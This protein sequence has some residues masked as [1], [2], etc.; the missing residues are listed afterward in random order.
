MNGHLSTPL[1]G[2]SQ[3]ADLNV[4]YLHLHLIKIDLLLRSAVRRWQLAGQDFA[5][6]FRGLFI[7]EEDVRSLLSRPIGGNWGTGVELPEE[8]ADTFR[9]LEEQIQHEIEQMQAQAAVRGE[10]LRLDDMK[11]LFR[12][13]QFEFDAFMLCVAPMLDTRYERIFGYLQD[14][15]TNHYAGI[16]LILD[17]LLTPG[18]DR[19]FY[20]D[21]FNPEAA[22]RKYDLI[23]RIDNGDEGQ[24]PLIRQRFF[25]PAEIITWLRGGYQAPERFA[26]AFRLQQGSRPGDAD[27]AD[28]PQDLPAMLQEKPLLVLY[29]QDELQQHLAARAIA[30]R[31][32]KP[33]LYLDLRHLPGGGE[34]DQQ[35][36]DLLAR[37]AMLTGA[38]PTVLGWERF[39]EGQ[40]DLD[41]FFQMLSTYPGVILLF[42]SQSW[43]VLR[44]ERE[45]IKAVVWLD[46]NHP[47]GTRRLQLWQHYLG[48]DISLPA[49]E[50]EA[51]SGQ[52]TLTA[53]QIS[54]AVFAAKDLAFQRSTP[55]TVDDLYEAARSYSSHHLGSLA[56]KIIPR[57]TWK[58]IVL[59]E[60]EMAA[61]HEIANTIRWR[62][63]VLEEWGV[64]ERLM[65]YAGVSALFAGPPGTG[66]TLAAQ[67]IANELKMDLYKIDLSTVVSKY[68]GETE[69]NLERIFSQAKNS[70]A[71]L[72]FDEADSIFGKRSEVKDAHDRYA[73]IEVGYLL[74]RMESYDGVVVLATNLRSNLDEAFTRRI[75]FII[76]FPFPDEE[77]RA[78]IWQVLFPAG[79]PRT[80]DIDF[81][82][83]GERF[84]LAGGSIR[85]VIVGAS[86][87]AASEDQPVHSRHLIHSIRRELQKMGRLVNEK[88]LS[89]TIQEGRNGK[90][91]T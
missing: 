7:S 4:R 41:L 84:K 33:L 34:P 14:D 35:L 62:S 11:A 77:E 22:L 80:D 40:A 45:R 43:P 42:H 15:V 20:F 50:L 52:F 72:F 68:I 88:D 82:T 91:A 32:S 66:K 2:P 21:C 17:L 63:V 25:V 26:A 30:G 38:I 85:N 29:G 16:A 53:G 55:L 44:G 78:R 83:F 10:T 13:T 9:R 37:D 65:P 81:Y 54:N 1:A 71:I 24:R 49:R 5:E 76:D 69:K 51:L 39:A 31:L 87:L 58:D 19:I 67:V 47:S 27:L 61:L 57:Y 18:L 79:V 56:A 36:V 86:F 23:H 75:Q 12:L 46:C 74:Q 3:G 64:G 28:L 90:H 89:I 48:E 59:P 60:D 8:E 73:N 70:N 6:K